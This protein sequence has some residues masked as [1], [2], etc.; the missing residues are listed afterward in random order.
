MTAKEGVY[1]PPPEVRQAGSATFGRLFQESASLNA[2]RTALIEGGRS[3]SYAELNDRS[4]RM[5]RILLDR[6]LDRGDRVGLLARNCIEFVEVEIAAA[7]IGVISVNLNWR[8]TPVELAHCAGLTAPSFIVSSEEFVAPLKE[9]GWQTDLVIGR[10]YDAALDTVDPV[11]RLEVFVEGEDGLCIL[12]TSGTT[13]MP[14]GALIS[15]R[16]MV[17]RALI[18]ATE[19]GAP[20][21][22]T[23]IAWSPLF[24]Y[25]I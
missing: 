9:A 1:R 7:K 12:F 20:K 6:G 24:P 3:R 15:H 23:F 13:G 11:D 8:Q 19:T 14:K 2:E 5:A 16:A 21:D 4:N 22:D 18:F 10:A 25:G 17:A